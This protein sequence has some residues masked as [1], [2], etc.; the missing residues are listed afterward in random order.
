VQPSLGE[1]LTCQ[2][3]PLVSTQYCT[4]R[5]VGQQIFTPPTTSV[6]TACHD[7][8][9]VLAHAQTNTASSGVEACATCHGPN[10]PW[11]VQ[12]VHEPAP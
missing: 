9:S 3:T 7:A 11:D 1:V 6:C 5:V 10:A 4:N 2:D 8:P 12:L